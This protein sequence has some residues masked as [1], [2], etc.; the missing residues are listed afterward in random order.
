[1]LERAGG[2][3]LDVTLLRT[4]A[5]SDRSELD[6]TVD[7]GDLLDLTSGGRAAL[8][9]TVSVLDL[10]AASAFAADGTHAL[11]VPVLWS[12][13]HFSEGAAGLQ[14]VEAPRLACGGP[15]ATAETAQLELTA[16]PVLHVG[17]VGG[18]AG[19]DVVAR[20]DVRLAGATGRLSSVTCGDAT[21]TR[22]EAVDVDVTRR[23]SEARLA[24]PLQLHGELAAAEVGVDPGLFGSPPVLGQ[25]TVTLDLTVEA[26]VDLSGTVGAHPATYAVPHH[27][28]AE[29]EPVG[30][31]SVAAL[32]LAQ[33]TT[34]DVTGTVTLGATTLD[35]VP[36]LG[37]GGIDLSGLLA[38]VNSQV[39]DAAVNPF[40]TRINEVLTPTAD[41][42]G[43]RLNGV[44]L[45]G[46][47]RPACA[48]PSL[49]G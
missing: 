6:A 35:V 22:P 33:V 36:L 3:A 48:A 26:G 4:L 41:L 29:P 12:V 49:R 10:V 13:P 9:G 30:D 46:V 11:D 25:P 17:T 40:I 15:G 21:P 45:Y 5:A 37:S 2:S 43:V 24:I 23:L 7:V 18:L 8:A 19:D 28:Y 42:L 20:L 27:T 39:V 34:S 38:S 47:P 44:D 1:V 16:E 32:P 14:V 31:T